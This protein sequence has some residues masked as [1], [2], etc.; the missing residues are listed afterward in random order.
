MYKK[1]ESST[2]NLTPK[3]IKGEEV[4]VQISLL[5]STAIVGQETEL[6][7]SLGIHTCFASGADTQCLGLR[8]AW[9]YQ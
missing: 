9:V 5:M 1:A 2:V 8:R 6:C 3:N 7:K 4:S